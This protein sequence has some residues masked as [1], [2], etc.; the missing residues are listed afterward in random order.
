MWI[1]CLAMHESCKNNEYELN[2]HA[3]WAINSTSKAK[4]FFD[5]DTLSCQSREKSELFEAD[6]R[7]NSFD[8]LNFRYEHGRKLL[9]SISKDVNYCLLASF[10]LELR[11]KPNIMWIY[12]VR[13]VLL[14]VFSCFV[15]PPKHQI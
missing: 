15:S 9:F 12:D 8:S 10:T 13:K 4:V 2:N 6:S 14:I 5:C 11:C 1:F 7:K 3:K